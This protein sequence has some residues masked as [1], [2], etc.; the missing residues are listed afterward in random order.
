[1]RSSLTEKTSGDHRGEN[2]RVD[3]S[4]SEEASRGARATLRFGL[5]ADF[6]ELGVEFGQGVVEVC[7]EAVVGDLEDRASSS[8]LMATMTLE[9]FMPA[10]CWIA[11][12][13]PTAM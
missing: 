8:L 11:P 9:S 1:V 13:M 2:R 3:A 6:G 12:E 5:L 10:R 7:D 4:F